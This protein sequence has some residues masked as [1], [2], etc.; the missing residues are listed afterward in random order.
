MSGQATSDRVAQLRPAMIECCGSWSVVISPAATEA[1]TYAADIGSAATS[2]GRACR[3]LQ[4]CRTVAAASAPT[5]A[6]TATRS[7]SV[8]ALAERVLD[9]AGAHKYE[10]RR[11]RGPRSEASGGFSLPP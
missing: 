4:K 11:G 10:N 8:V 6:W 3:T 2:N 1:S 9:Y 7:R 5:P